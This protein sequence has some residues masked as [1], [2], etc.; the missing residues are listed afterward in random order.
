MQRGLPT[1]A[2]HSQMLQ[3]SVHAATAELSQYA[4]RFG[5]QTIPSNLHLHHHMSHQ[6]HLQPQPPSSSAGGFQQ[7]S[8]SQPAQAQNSAQ[9]EE[10]EGKNKAGAAL[11]AQ[12]G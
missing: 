6:P 2:Q 12:A 1:Y 5:F 11:D 8:C 4:S 3:Q 9:A 7:P 10:H